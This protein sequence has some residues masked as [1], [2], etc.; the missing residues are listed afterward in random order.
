MLIPMHPLTCRVWISI[1]TSFIPNM[2]GFHFIRYRPYIGCVPHREPS[3]QGQ[4]HWYTL[5]GLSMAMRLGDC[6]ER[7]PAA[8]FCILSNLRDF[9][10]RVITST[11]QGFHEGIML[12]LRL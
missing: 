4:L 8:T 12:P 7:S 2:Y 9:Y 10:W 6:H 5:I 3:H 11:L 1:Y